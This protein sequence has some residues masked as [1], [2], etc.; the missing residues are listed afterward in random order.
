MISRWTR[1]V[2]MRPAPSLDL[3]C[4][5]TQGKQVFRDDRR[6]LWSPVALGAGAPPT[7]DLLAPLR[8]G[9]ADLVTNHSWNV[10][11]LVLLPH[12][13]SAGESRRWAS[14]ARSA[15]A[16]APYLRSMVPS[17]Q[18]AIRIKSLSLPACESQVWAKVCRN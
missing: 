8:C 5:D 7:A 17:L 14:R 2:V 10:R 18:P 13:R 3:R 12:K 4:I 6:Q 11:R 16:D 1:G 15:P 9:V